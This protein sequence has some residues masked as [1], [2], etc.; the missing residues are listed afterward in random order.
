M[1]SLILMAAVRGENTIATSQMIRYPEKATNS[2]YT[3]SIWACPEE[4]YIE[5]LRAYFTFCHE[6]YRTWGYRP[7][8]MHVGYRINKDPSSLFSYSFGATV[9][10]FDP[11]ST[12]MRAGNSFW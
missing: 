9:M 10:T 12:G 2:R 4:R 8:M 6:Y 5:N 7:N 11:V 1:K 3:F